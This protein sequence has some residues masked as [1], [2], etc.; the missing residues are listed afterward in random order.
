[1]HRRES[2]T[3]WTT[4]VLAPLIVA[5][6]ACDGDST[7]PE[8]EPE[9]DHVVVADGISFTDIGNG[10]FRA[11]LTGVHPTMVSFTD[12]PVRESAHVPIEMLLLWDRLFEGTDPNAS[13]VA[14]DQ[15]GVA[16]DPIAFTM[17]A[18]TLDTLQAEMSFELTLL[19]D[20]QITPANMS[21]MEVALFIDPSAGQWVRLTLTCGG[22]IVAFIAGLAFVEAP[23]IAAAL[24]AGGFTLT[25]ACSATIGDA[26]P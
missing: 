4:L 12:R 1:M 2:D 24:V 14:Y 7:G 26:F 15:D 5:L 11:T 25:V 9:W 16:E 17:F 19:G 22:A 8:P 10:R 13:V 18:P 23:P 6:A 21:G 20:A 3:F